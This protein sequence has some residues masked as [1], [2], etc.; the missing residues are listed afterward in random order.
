MKTIYKA[1]SN[2]I[3]GSSNVHSESSRSH[4]MFTLER[5]S[6]AALNII[7]LCGCEVLTYKFDEKQREE[8]N[9]INLSLFTLNAVINDLCSQKKDKNQFIPFRNSVL[10]RLLKKSLINEKKTQIY[11]FCNIAPEEK[12]QT[13][14]SSTLRFGQVAIS[15][16]EAQNVV[17]EKVNLSQQK[18]DLRKVENII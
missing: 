3:F 8:T 9:A 1:N 6:G 18:R 13:Y 17:E 14:S 4:V 11:L 5:K 2:K 16:D 7:D 12:H 10:T 15:V